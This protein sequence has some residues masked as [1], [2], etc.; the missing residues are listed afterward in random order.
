MNILKKW[1]FWVIV[2]IILYF[3]LLLIGC[4]GNLPRPLGI[5]RFN[6]NEEC[7][8][9]YCGWIPL[10]VQCTMTSCITREEHEQFLRTR[11][12]EQYM[13]E[14]ERDN[15]YIERANMG[16]YA[17]D[18]CKKILNLKRRDTCYFHGAFFTRN[19]ALCDLVERKDQCLSCI[20]NPYQSFDCPT[21][22]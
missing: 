12:C 10:A 11:N 9:C 21:I 4:R 22:K 2:L 6:P 20:E 8:T 5:G 7:R 1:W 16:Y 18:E 15:C 17:L 19:K 3:S 13:G 14:V